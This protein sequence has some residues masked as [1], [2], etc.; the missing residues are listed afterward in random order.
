MGN[1]SYGH[2]GFSTCMGYNRGNDKTT[3]PKEISVILA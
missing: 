2:D 1:H 3:H